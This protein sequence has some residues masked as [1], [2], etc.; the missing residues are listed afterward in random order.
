[1]GAS[2]ISP[3]MEFAGTCGAAARADTS[4]EAPSASPSL[5]KGRVCILSRK[6]LR[7]ITRVPR[8]A[9]ALVDAGYAA[10]VVCLR[11]PVLELRELC[12]QTE[13]VEVAPRTVTGAILNAVNARLGRRRRLRQ[14]REEACRKILDRGGMLAPVLRAG[15][16]AARP[17]R[18]MAELARSMLVGAPCALLLRKRGQTYSVAWRGLSGRQAI[19]V[20]GM[21]L[22]SLQQRARTHVFAAAA[23]RALRGRRFDVVQAHDNYALVAAARL[24]A[25]DRARL[26]YDAVELASHRLG[27][28]LNLCERVSEWFERREEAAIFRRADALTTVGEGLADWYARNYSVARPLVVR[29]CRYFWPYRR[30]LRLRADIG[31]GPETPIAVWFG[32]AY[33]EQGIELLIEAAPLMRRA[34]HVVIVASFQPRFAKFVEGL[35]GL[36][37]RLGVESRVHVLPARSPNDLVPYVSGADI[38]VIPRPSGHLNNFYSMPNKFLEMVMARLPVAVS[39]LGDIVDA[40]RKYDIG[41]V[42]DERE[43]AEI[44][45]AVETMLEPDT[46]ARLRANVIRA[47]EDMTWEKESAAYL[48]LV[49]ALTGRPAADVATRG[50]RVLGSALDSTK[51]GIRG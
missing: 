35:P 33:P 44:A 3:A 51:R 6:D 1:M 19:D 10:T 21:L 28:D 49:R 23:D 39:Q 43:P 4:P 22:M 47:A 18:R 20:F 34:I 2:P 26:V 8:M 11:A 48:E 36:A 29:N 24:A 25:R 46:Y 31:V 32:G 27:L 50:F 14:R 30:D 16:A 15:C 13:Y 45:R 37:A 38:G 9:K 12:P 40:V 17:V 5:P 42:F 7:D 41:A